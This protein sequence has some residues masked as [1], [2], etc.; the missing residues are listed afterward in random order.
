[1]IIMKN[2]L[3]TF[4]TLGMAFAL[5]QIATADVDMSGKTVEWTIPFSEKGGGGK[6]G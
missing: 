3:R 2:I 1:M 4:I 5:P 6:M